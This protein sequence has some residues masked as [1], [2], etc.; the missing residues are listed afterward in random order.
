[1]HVEIPLQLRHVEAQDV[2]E[3]GDGG[4]GPGIGGRGQIAPEIVAHQQAAAVD[5]EHAGLRR[6]IVQAE[7]AARGDAN[8]AGEDD[9]IPAEGEG[10]PL[11]EKRLPGLPRREAGEKSVPGRVVRGIGDRGG[12]RKERGPGA[13]DGRGGQAEQGEGEGKPHVFFGRRRVASWA[14]RRI[15]RH[16]RERLSRR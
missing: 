1:V 4:L 2:D 6:E 12:G 9:G 7:T 8:F 14:N 16:A 11:L 10:A 13:E 3:R 5:D 15:C